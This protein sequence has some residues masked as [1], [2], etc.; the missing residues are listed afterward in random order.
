MGVQHPKCLVLVL[1]VAHE[2]GENRVFE[3]IREIAGVIDVAV[4][5]GCV[6]LAVYPDEWSG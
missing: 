5:H 4:V 3:N 2:A 6:S 1:Q